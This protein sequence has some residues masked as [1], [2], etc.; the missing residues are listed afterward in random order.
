MKDEHLAILGKPGKDVVTGFSGVVTSVSFDLYGCAQAVITPPTDDKGEVK[1]GQ[2]FDVARIEVT[3]D[4]PVMRVP[5]FD[6]GYIASG[7]KG[8]AEKPLP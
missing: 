1:N 7:L 2:W 8:A 5:N 4:E 6:E 3:S